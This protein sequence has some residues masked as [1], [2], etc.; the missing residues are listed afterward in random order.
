MHHNGQFKVLGKFSL[1]IKLTGKNF[2]EY[3]EP[4]SC[5]WIVVQI[6]REVKMHHEGGLT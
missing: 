3:I 1:L 4:F 5:C 6:E 2:L